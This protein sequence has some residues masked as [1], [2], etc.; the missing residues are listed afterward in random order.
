MRNA[1]N[2]R[3]V[4]LLLTLAMLACG[5]MALGGTFA[6]QDSIDR[7]SDK[8]KEEIVYDANSN[9]L[10]YGVSV[11]YSEKLDGTYNDLFNGKPFE[12]TLWCPGYTKVIYIK[13]Q[14]DE[15][16]PVECTLDLKITKNDFGNMMAY[17]VI[18]PDEENKLPKPTNWYEFMT[19]E[20]AKSSSLLSQKNNVFD[21]VYVAAEAYKTYALAMHMED[22]AGNEYKKAQLAMKFDFRVDAN[23][24]PGTAVLGNPQ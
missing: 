23:Y 14:N 12:N 13:V 5:V 9:V 20:R 4:L 7:I 22:Q 11:T 16:F 21:K 17:A 3:L 1:G 15:K 10:K 6:N 18:S 24:E 2:K 19:H 8:T